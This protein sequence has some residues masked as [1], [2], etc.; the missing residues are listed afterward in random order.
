MEKRIN[1]LQEPESHP[2]ARLVLIGLYSIT[3]VES[4]CL[5]TKPSL[6][7]VAQRKQLA[8]QFSPTCTPCGVCLGLGGGKALSDMTFGCEQ[9]AFHPLA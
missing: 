9:H 5:A 8:S 6:C 1:V 4:L 2:E 7:G 3:R